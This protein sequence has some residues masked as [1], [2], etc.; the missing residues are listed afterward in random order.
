M[1]RYVFQ[2]FSLGI[3][4]IFSMRAKGQSHTFTRNFNAKVRLKNLLLK[5][6][7]SNLISRARDAQ[8]SNSYIYLISLK[9][10][11][12]INYIRDKD[13]YYTILFEIIQI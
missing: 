5:K 12:K 6:K 1:T 9:H 7:L 13:D 8:I 2:R 10:P 4:H 3:S 11:F